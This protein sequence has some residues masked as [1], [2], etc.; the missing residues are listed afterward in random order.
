MVTVGEPKLNS[1][2]DAPTLFCTLA[3]VIPDR[4]LEDIEMVVGEGTDTGTE[5]LHV[6]SVDNATPD[7]V[8]VLSPGVAVTEPPHALVTVPD[9]VIGDGNVKVNPTPEAEVSVCVFDNNNDND[10]ELFAMVSANDAS[11]VTAWKF[12]TVY[13]EYVTSPGVDPRVNCAHNSVSWLI[14]VTVV[15]MS[16]PFLTLLRNVVLLYAP[17]YRP[18]NVPPTASR[19]PRIFLDVGSTEI[20]VSTGS[21]TRVPTPLSDPPGLVSPPL[22]SLTVLELPSGMVTVKFSKKKRLG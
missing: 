22:Y 10:V 5:M 6:A 21:V 4:L 15:P 2:D 20:I 11:T 19:N 3:G 12:V 14:A 9:M 17:E 8:M 13:R 18:V 16:A 1:T 7:T